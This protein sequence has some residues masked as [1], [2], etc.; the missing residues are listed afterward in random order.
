M[1]GLAPLLINLGWIFDWMR[2]TFAWY[3]LVSSGY[4]GLVRV[5]EVWLGLVLK[6]REETDLRKISLVS[7]NLG[8][9]ALDEAHFC[10]VYIGE[11]WH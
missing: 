2:L 1:V 6:V 4:G 9:V 7:I 3:I 5:S 11:G 10:F 8:W